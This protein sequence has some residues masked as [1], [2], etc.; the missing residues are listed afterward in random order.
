MHDTADTLLLALDGIQN[1]FALG[2]NARVHAH[3]GQLT[4]ERVGHQLEGQSRELLSIVG[5]AAQ[6]LL[7]VIGI[8]T[9][10]VRDVHRSGQIV[11]HGVQHAL[12][13][14]VLERGT[15]QHGLD[16]HSQGT[17]TD[18][19]LHFFFRQSTLFQVLVHQVFRSFG[20][21]FHQV[22]APLVGGFHQLSGD[23]LVFE[24]HALGSFVPDDGLHLDQVHHAL[25]VV[26]SADWDHHGHRIALQAGLDLVHNLKE[27]G[28][29]TVHLVHEG[30]TRH[31]VLVSLTPHGFGLGLHA[32][33]SAVH[34]ASTVQHAHGTLH[35]N[36]EVHVAGGVDDV[37]TVFG[38]GQVHT[39]PE[40]GHSSRSNRDAALLFL[41]HPVGRSSTIVHFAQLV[42]HAC[43]EQDTF[44]RGGFA[45]VDVRRNTDITVALDGGLA[46][47]DGSLIDRMGDLLDPALCAGPAV[48]YG[49]ALNRD[50]AAASFCVRPR[51]R[52]RNSD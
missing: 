14:L 32:A 21:G 22:F 37:E 11:D 29:G 50:K 24:L 5:L 51:S 10:N 52:E 49:D 41:L 12:H 34:H 44:G 2:Q 43:V 16:F 15:A 6:L 19:G 13:T 25:E 18:T 42:G 48:Q 47:H 26:F 33:H 1:G 9:G 35:F 46:S 3:E 8:G 17:G 20:S 38:V 31:L 4:H 7:F 23:F 36:R 39:L 30:Q 40:A 45:C 28:T 27:V